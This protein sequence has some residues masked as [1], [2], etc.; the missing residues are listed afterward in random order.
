[1]SKNL[2][3]CPFCGRKPEIVNCG[4]EVC[5]NKENGDIITRWKVR[6]IN[7]GTEKDGGCSEYWIRNDETLDLA[8]NKDGREEAISKWNSRV[9]DIMELEK[10]NE[11]LRNCVEVLERR[12]RHLL[13]SNFIASF[14]EY[15]PKTK[16]YKRDIKEADTKNEL[17][18]MPMTNFEKIKSMSIEE[19]AK[20]LDNIT[21]ACSS[22]FDCDH[23][24]VKFPGAACCYNSFKSWLEAETTGGMKQNDGNTGIY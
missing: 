11:D 9:T 5:R 6:C 19:L 17:P 12:L 7:C 15:D 1:M 16:S 10:E 20:L 3:P 21:D 22:G 13:Q 18:K 8:G 23:C 2:K 24:P 4:F 14:D